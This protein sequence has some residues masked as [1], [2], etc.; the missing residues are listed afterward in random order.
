LS[1]L[2]IMNGLVTFV[3]VNTLTFNVDSIENIQVL[4]Y[5]QGKDP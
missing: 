2:H 3:V 4:L 1:C 5:T